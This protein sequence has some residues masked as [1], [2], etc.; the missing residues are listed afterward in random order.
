MRVKADF[1]ALR[2]MRE[3]LAR[4]PEV[5]EAVAAVAAPAVSSLAGDTFDSGRG[6]YGDPFAP[7]KDGSTRTLKKSGRL[8]AQI[9]FVQIGT[10]IRC[11]LGVRYAKYRIKDGIL[12]RG[13][14][15]LP[16]R[17]T[18]EIKRLAGAEMATRLGGSP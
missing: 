16:V 7:N 8:R 9:R 4:L 1:A 18:A 2:T 3:K 11:V 14:A 12:P 6:V 13:G 10:K 15:A 17:W 5:Q